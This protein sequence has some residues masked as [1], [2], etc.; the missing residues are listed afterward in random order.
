VGA[1]VEV[2][3]SPGRAPN[4]VADR[5]Q[6]K[7]DAHGHF[8]AHGTG[9]LEKECAIVIRR[10]GRKDVERKVANYCRGT[11]LRC[12]GMCNDVFA[13]IELP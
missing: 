12:R 5:Q 11:S 7:S 13:E 4:D 10:E 8:E 9:C 6:M 3:C 1:I 2:R